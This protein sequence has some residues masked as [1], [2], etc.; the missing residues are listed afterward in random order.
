MSNL[1]RRVAVLDR[2]A[3]HDWDRAMLALYGETPPPSDRAVAR[4]LEAHQAVD[5]RRRAAGES[6][7][8]SIAQALDAI[9]GHQAFADHAGFLGVINDRDH[10]AALRVAWLATFDLDAQDDTDDMTPPRQTRP[11]D[12][13]EQGPPIVR[14]CASTSTPNGPPHRG[15]APH[16]PVLGSMARSR[17]GP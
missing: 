5:R 2:R 17:S 6:P 3:G 15:F 9:P 1:G 11:D 14:P 16:T 8:V 10:K 4:R 12:E 7:R 13:N